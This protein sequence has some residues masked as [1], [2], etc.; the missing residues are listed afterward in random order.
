MPCLNEE[1]VKHPPSATATS[2]AVFD[3]GLNMLY[4]L[5]VIVALSIPP[6]LSAEIWYNETPAVWC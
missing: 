2:R 1:S 3:A 4:Y 6:M 5:N